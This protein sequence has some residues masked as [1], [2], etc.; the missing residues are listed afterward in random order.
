M[1]RVPEAAPTSGSAAGVS[2]PARAGTAPALPGRI[3][4]PAWPEIVERANASTELP[5]SV[6]APVSS[7]RGAD[8]GQSHARQTADSVRLAE[9]PRPEA[10]SA[11][12]AHLDGDSDSIGV[13][14]DARR[15]AGPAV[16]GRVGLLVQVTQ[17][18]V[19]PA[20]AVSALEPEVLPAVE[21]DR[22]V[23]TAGQTPA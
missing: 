7:R 13:A 15:A 19:W 8:R 23:A 3:L 18:A 4:G 9:H 1:V 6:F 20:Q 22:V 10:E 2:N 14:L 5:P 17:V 16:R 12:L 11:A 21:A